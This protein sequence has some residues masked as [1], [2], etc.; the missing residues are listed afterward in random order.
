MPVMNQK[1]AVL[2]SCEQAL[3][4][5]T[6]Q[7]SIHLFTEISVTDGIALW[8]ITTGVTVIHEVINVEGQQIIKLQQI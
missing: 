8:V 7:K 4:P 1:I 6:E 2:G 5:K 3:N